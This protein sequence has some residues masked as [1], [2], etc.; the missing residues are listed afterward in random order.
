MSIFK[1]EKE[2]KIYFWNCCDESGKTTLLYTIKDGF[3]QATLPTV[4][5]NIETITF[6]GVKM[7]I[8]EVGGGKSFRPHYYPGSDAIIFLIDSSALISDK[9]TL[10]NYEDL[11]ECI[12]SIEDLPLLIAITKIDIRKT[13][14]ADIINAYHLNSLFERKQKIGIIECSSYTQEG[15]KEILFWL[16]TVN[17]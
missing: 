11:Q 13:S 15:I 16:S 7:H 4:G 9:Y 17:K 6:N 14:T 5:F 8:L 10:D 2:L 1:K 3:V 12:N